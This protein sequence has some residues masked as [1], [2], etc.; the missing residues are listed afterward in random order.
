MFAVELKIP[1]AVKRLEKAD[2]DELLTKV[3]ESQQESVL[4]LISR[5]FRRGEDPYGKPW[6]APNKL[7][8]TGGIKAY[9][10]GHFGSDGF[11][12]HS[13]DEKAPWH[14]FGTGVHGPEKRPYRIDNFFGR[15]GVSIMH[16]GVPQRLQVPTADRGL[17]TD[18]ADRLRRTGERALKTLLGG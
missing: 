4:N 9:A 8:I 2:A 5:G 12:V 1:T 13:T 18:W 6:N 11:Q 17:P 3:A 15:P 16:P 7:Q 14:H 10:R